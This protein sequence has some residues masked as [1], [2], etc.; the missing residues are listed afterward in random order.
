[1]G[2]IKLKFDQFRYT[3]LLTIP[4]SIDK[5]ESC[6]DNHTDRLE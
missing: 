5:R 4:V 3:F 2:Q 6:N 1:M